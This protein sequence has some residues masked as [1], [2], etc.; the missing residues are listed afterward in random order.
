M[1]TSL[2]ILFVFCAGV[3][4]ARLDLVP[5]DLLMPDLT[6]YILWALMLLIG[7]SIGADK[8]L[9][10][11]LRS[12]RPSVLLLPLATTVGTFAGVAIAS[13]FLTYSVTEC[14]AVGAGFGYYSISSVFIAQYKGAELGAVALLTNL[15]RE[16]FTLLFTPL[17]VRLFGPLAPISSGGATSMDTTLPGILRYSGKEWVFTS[18]IHAMVLDTS[19]PFWVIF[20]C[21]Q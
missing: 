4:L 18:I 17:L 13:I 11:I 19:V 21:H 7:F 14:L 2:L 6:L 9:K 8:R 5:R 15:S 3:A 1:K 16:I 10:E 20:F 12:L